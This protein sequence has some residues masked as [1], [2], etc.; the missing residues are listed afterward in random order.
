RV[1]LVD[2]GVGANDGGGHVD[3]IVVKAD[4]AALDARRERALSSVGLTEGE[5]WTRVEAGGATPDERDACQEVDT[6]RFLLER[7]TTDNETEL[8]R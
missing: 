2:S 5:L 8:H 4:R 1:G 3:A 6:V 7:S